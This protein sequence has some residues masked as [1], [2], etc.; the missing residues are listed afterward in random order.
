MTERRFWLLTCVALLGLGTTA[1]L[2]LPSPPSDGGE[3]RVRGADPLVSPG[4]EEV[5]AVAARIDKHLAAGWSA[6]AVEPAPRADDAE[7]LRRVY[8]DVA[9]RIP[10]VA[11]ARAF[12]KDTSPDKRPRLVER[13]LQSPRYVTHGVHVWRTLL[14]PEVSASIQARFLAPGFETWLQEQFAKNAGYDTMIRDLLTAPIDRNNPQAA[15]SRS[16]ASNPLA[17]IL[18]KEAR[19]ENLAAATARV[20]LGIR[21]ECAQCHDHPFATWKRDQFWSFAA[22]FGG[23][24]NQGQGDFAFPTQ[25]IVD[26]RELV[27][28]GTE[29]VVQATFPDGTEPAWEF[30][31]SSRRTLANWITSPQ[32]PYFARATVNRMWY[33]FFGRGL[34]EPVDEMVG[35]ESIA[36]HPELLDELAGAFVAQRFDL[37]FLIRALTAS[38]AYQLTSATTQPDQNDP[39]LFARMPL[40]GL[41]AE[42]LLDS[43]AQATGYRDTSPRDPRILGGPTTGRDELLTKFTEQSDRPTEFQTTILQA[44]ALM[45]GRLIADQTTLERSDLLAAILEAPFLDTAE[46][47]ETL[48][49]ATLSRK[50]KPKELQR[51]LGF[52]ENSEGENRET[53]RKQ[54]MTDLFWALLNSG[55][56]LLNH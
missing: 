49:L 30:R 12:L 5:R 6:A 25:E 19:P 7:F 21:L 48:Y 46:Q 18:A 37:K 17:Y 15:F 9:G 22:F 27:I 2:T 35:A 54:A 23:I 43:V 55:E 51:A 50:P 31:V 40:R 20:F 41:S 1:P 3:G 36:S 32:N 24:K 10:S 4:A 16:Q 45:N 11:D 44:L 34:V 13:L 39:R 53:A 42:Q 33:Q 8:L 52:I 26:R 47:I 29:R 38:Q 56:F 14:L 28:P